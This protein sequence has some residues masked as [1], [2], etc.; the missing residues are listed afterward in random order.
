MAMVN[1]NIL[2]SIYAP[3]TSSMKKLSKAINQSIVINE[4]AYLLKIIELGFKDNEMIS[5][6]SMAM[7]ILSPSPIILKDEKRLNQ[8]QDRFEKIIGNRTIED[9]FRRALLK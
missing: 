9:V 7:S 8:L 2:N 4:Y 1:L 5:Y 6:L 3:P